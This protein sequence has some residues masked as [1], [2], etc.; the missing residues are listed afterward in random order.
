MK[1]MELL[2]RFSRNV[3]SLSKK[4][5][6]V[7]FAHQPPIHI[8]LPPKERPSHPDPRPSKLLGL[9]KKTTGKKIQWE[10]NSKIDFSFFSMVV[11]IKHF[12]IWQICTYFSQNS[13]I[14]QLFHTIRKILAWASILDQPQ[15]SSS[16]G[17]GDVIDFSRP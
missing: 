4:L 6:D 1:K 16:L 5:L 2:M 3:S 9:L 17:L 13:T 15:L 11:V 7:V 14:L 10:K 8:P 12:Q